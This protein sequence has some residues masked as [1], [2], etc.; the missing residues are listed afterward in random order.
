MTKKNKRYRGISDKTGDKIEDLYEDLKLKERLKL[1]TFKKPKPTTFKEWY[2]NFS[3]GSIVMIMMGVMFWYFMREDTFLA[4]AIQC[5]IAYPIFVLLTATH[6]LLHV[7]QATRRG[8]QY[9]FVYD[10]KASVEVFHYNDDK[11]KADRIM[12]LFTS[13]LVLIPLSAILFF[14]GYY[15][16]NWSLILSGGG[17]MLH[18]AVYMRWDYKGAMQSEKAG[19]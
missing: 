17:V 3:I 8:Y 9:D 19:S 18:Q 15:F 13:Y 11:W 14:I 7:V 4:F 16:S 5:F 2:R 12:I 10:K 6:E 1:G